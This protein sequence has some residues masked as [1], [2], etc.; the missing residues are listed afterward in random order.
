M[1]RKNLELLKL[2]SI[3]M[4]SS[5]LVQGKKKNKLLIVGIAIALLAIIIFG[6][7][8]LGIY[9]NNAIDKIKLGSSLILC[10]SLIFS[11]YLFVFPRGKFGIKLMNKTGLNTIY[12]IIFIVITLSIS[13]L[14]V[15]I[16][17]P[18]AFSKHSLRIGI[19]ITSVIGIIHI[20]LSLISFKLLN[21]KNKFELNAEII[22]EDSTQLVKIRQDQFIFIKACNNYIEVYTSNNSK[23]YLLRQTLKEFL[24]K[25]PLSIL[26]RCHKSYVINTSKVTSISGNSKGYMVHV[27]EINE[28]SIPVSRDKGTEL[29]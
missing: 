20:V 15:S 28:L 6:I 13:L 11:F 3:R 14:I 10:Y 25:N 21:I 18:I 29:K 26:Y 19:T 22:I 2:F 9:K 5:F 24:E 27:K 7:Q 8:P 23:P 12:T 17:R 1:N 16:F 4:Q